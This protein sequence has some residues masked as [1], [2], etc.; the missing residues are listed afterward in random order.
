MLRILS[1]EATPF[2]VL[3]FLNVSSGRKAVRELLPFLR[4]Q[5]EGLPDGLDAL[6]VTADLQGRVRDACGNAVTRLLGESVAECVEE[7]ASQGL[8]PATNRI[9][10]VLAG[11]FYCCEGLDKRG[12]SGMCDQFG[13][14][15]H[16]AFGGLLGSLEITTYS[17]IVG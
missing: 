10:V 5:I 8:L 17:V 7:L 11:D 1:I 13:R 12:G 15:L 6:L 9:G 16:C 14:H 3:P 4:G 2:H